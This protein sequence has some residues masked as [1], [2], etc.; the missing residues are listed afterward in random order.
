MTHPAML[1]AVFPLAA[2][3]IGSTPFGPMIGL[4]HGMDIR[5]HGSGNV[6]A[7]NVGRLFGKRWGYTCFALDVAK[8]FVPV[9][10]AGRFM[11]SGAADVPA[12]GVQA[13]WLLVAAAAICGHVL[14]FWLGFR[15]GKGVATGLGAVCGVWPFLAQAG[16]AALAVWIIVTS[17]SRYVSLG[18]VVAAAAFFPLFVGLNWLSLGEWPLVRRLWPMGIFALA[19]PAMIIIRHRGNISRLLAGTENK[20][21]RP[22]GPPANA[23]D[24]QA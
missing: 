6:G 4:L 8:G 23:A 12:V 22:A 24:G 19:I 17:L 7:T 10:V 20:I 9:F 3:L 21:G 11:F 2:Y 13:A 16:L 1:F 14:S 5:R 15:G 18:S